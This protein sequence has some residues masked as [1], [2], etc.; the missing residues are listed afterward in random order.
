MSGIAH[1]K[2]VNLRSYYTQHFNNMINNWLPIGI[3]LLGLGKKP[4][5][6]RTDNTISAAPPQKRL[7]KED[8]YVGSI[9]KQRF[10]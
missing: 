2:Q 8:Q 10:A 7:P 1:V 9:L 4:S 3:R 6:S 5:I